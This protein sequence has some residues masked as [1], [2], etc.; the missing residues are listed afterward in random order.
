MVA[1]KGATA[2]SKF[3]VDDVRQADPAIGK[4]FELRTLTIAKRFDAGPVLNAYDYADEG[5]HEVIARLED[6]DLGFDDDAISSRMPPTPATTT[7]HLSRSGGRQGHAGSNKILRVDLPPERT[8]AQADTGSFL[9]RGVRRAD[10]TALV[11]RRLEF[12]I[13][14]RRVAA[15][16]RARSPHR[17]APAGRRRGGA[18]S[19]RSTVR[20]PRRG[21]M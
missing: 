3:T 14:R 15:R 19:P 7:G 12:Y 13:A 10:A 11:L 18:S 21:T 1:T 5:L 16:P 4:G 9:A 20:W 6:L 2:A 17:V 8:G